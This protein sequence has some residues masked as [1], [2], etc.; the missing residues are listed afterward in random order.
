MPSRALAP[1][2]PVGFWRTMLNEADRCPLRLIDL[3]LPMTIETAATAL[4]Q[5]FEQPDDE[6]EIILTRSGE[7][8]APAPADEERPDARPP[9][10][11]EAPTLSLGFQFPGNCAI[12]AGRR[13]PA[14]PSLPIRSKSMCGRPASTS[15]T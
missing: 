5:E 11:I 2:P 14:E 13:T 7:R 12:C 6:Q 15:A 3:E 10:P 4:D 1:T 9:T 8:Y